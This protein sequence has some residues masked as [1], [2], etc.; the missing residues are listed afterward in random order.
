MNYSVVISLG[1]TARHGG[2]SLILG[3]SSGSLGWVS[4]RERR[5]GQFLVKYCAHECQDFGCLL[6]C[7]AL[8]ITCHVLCAGSPPPWEHLIRPNIH[9]LARIQTSGPVQQP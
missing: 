2:I 8:G 3:D 1:W 9:S 5:G 6:G 7:S 4:D